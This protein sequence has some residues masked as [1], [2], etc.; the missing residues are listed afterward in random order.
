MGGG[1]GGGGALSEYTVS[2]IASLI[3]NSY[4]SVVAHKL[5]EHIST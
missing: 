3:D 5:S 4:I 1:K 2:E